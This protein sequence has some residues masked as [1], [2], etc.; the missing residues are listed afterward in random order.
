MGDSRMFG[1]A[2]LHFV[3]WRAGM[4]AEYV[5]NNFYSSRHYPNQWRV[6]ELW[7]TNHGQTSPAVQILPG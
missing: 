5:H 2:V 1:E 3:G 4:F 7:E 6:R